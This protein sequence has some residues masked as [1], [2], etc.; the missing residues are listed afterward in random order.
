MD[1]HTYETLIDAEIALKKFDRQYKNLQKFHA[2]QFLDLDN[3]DRREQRMLERHNQRQIDSY[4]VF[5]GGLSEEELMYKDY[6]QTDIEE[7]GENEA[8]ELSVD[9]EVVR[10]L[11]E[12][13]TDN[14]RFNASYSGVAS[15]DTASIVDQIVFNFRNRRQIDSAEDY[16]RRQSRLVERQI[17]RATTGN[18]SILLSPCSN[19]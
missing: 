15:D 12:Y 10:S 13:R 5:F 11:P 1:R 6:F 14:F 18:V 8:F 7:S 2:R 19:R 16:K 4:T 9:E 3:H 17:E